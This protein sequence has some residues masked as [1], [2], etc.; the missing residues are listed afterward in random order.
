[1]PAKKKSPQASKYLLSEVDALQYSELQAENKRY[2]IKASGQASEL[3]ATL[4]AHIRSRGTTT[5][6]N[7]LRGASGPIWDLP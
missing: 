6:T 7:S 1:M 4:K 3:L 5:S 2:G